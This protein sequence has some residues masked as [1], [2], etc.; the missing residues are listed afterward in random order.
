MFA[1]YV[2]FFF[3]GGGGGGGAEKGR[4]KRDLEPSFKELLEKSA[5]WCEC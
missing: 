3:L 1:V 4:K 5:S 2:S